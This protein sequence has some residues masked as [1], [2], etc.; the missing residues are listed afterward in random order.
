MTLVYFNNLI[1]QFYFKDP[2]VEVE[3]R[4]V[5]TLQG[6]QRESCTVIFMCLCVCISSRNQTIA[7]GTTWY[8]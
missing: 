8:L 6:N 3:T 1:Y 4:E 2:E 7:N 5:G